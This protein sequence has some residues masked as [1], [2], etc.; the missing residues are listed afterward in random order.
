MI[1]CYKQPGQHDFD[2]KYVPSRSSA[3]FLTFSVGIFEWVP[4]SNRPGLK[5]G[6]VK[7]R[8]SGSCNAPER[9]YMKAREI[10]QEL[11]QGCYRGHKHVRL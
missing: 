9:I 3:T 8:V 4:R 7:V 5:K 1:N 11:D 10:V 6:P 2:G